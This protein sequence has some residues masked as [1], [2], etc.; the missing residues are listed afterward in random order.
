[1][2]DQYVLI[3]D[4][5]PNVRMLV[6]DALTLLGYETLT[7]RT[8]TEAL[9][10]VRQRPPDAMILDLMMPGMTGFSVLASLRH[11]AGGREIPVIVLSALIDQTKG[12]ESLPGVVGAM[13]KGKFSFDGFRHLVGKLALKAA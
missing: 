3:V 1:M 9:E 10:I 5:D 8:G 4:D 7:A 6:K 2:N 13:C 12:V 11:A